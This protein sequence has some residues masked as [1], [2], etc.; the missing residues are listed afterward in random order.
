M[1][2]I[3]ISE[4]CRPRQWKTISMKNL[5]EEG[6]PVYGANGIIGYYDEYTHEKDTL[7]ITCR[8][9]TC[10]SINMSEEKAY[11]NGNAMALDDLNNEIIDIKYFYYYLLGYDF[12]DII[13]GSAQPQITRTNLNRLKIPV[14][15][16]KIQKQIVE[17]LDEAQVLVD[18]R[19]EQIELLDDLIESVF[20]DMFGDPVRNDKGWELKKLG[21]LGELGRGKSKHRPRNDSI[22]Y[23][24]EFPFI[25]TGDVAKSGIYLDEYETTYSK[26]GLEQSKMW[27]NNTLCITIAANI[28]KT[29]ILKINA[30][31]PDSIVGFIS[32]EGSNVIYIRTWFLFFQE[33]IEK[34]APQSAQRNINLRILND[35]DVIAPPIQLQNQFAEKVEL[36]ELQKQLLEDSLELLR[37]NYNSLMQKAFKGQLF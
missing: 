32:N 22:L 23:G 6:Y 26:K 15:P 37:G 28:A 34:S 7:M 20:Y 27:P 11:V 14:P 30:C 10:G 17:I 1:E 29:S 21:E 35:L 8:G 2:W 16:I 3:S 24:G 12:T 36:I 25:Q 13:S 18:N 4:V 31:F 19:K 5:K 9:A 33:I